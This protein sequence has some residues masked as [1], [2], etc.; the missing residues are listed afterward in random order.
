MNPQPGHGLS[1]F[2]GILMSEAEHT[3]TRTHAEYT[4]K[5]EVS[6]VSGEMQ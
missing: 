4:A 5:A 6:N 1:A 2:A 3:H